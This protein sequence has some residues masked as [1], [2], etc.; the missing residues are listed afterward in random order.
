MR[1]ATL[2]A[3]RITVEMQ[4]DRVILRGTVQS[5]TERQEAERITWPLPGVTSVDNQ[6][7]ISA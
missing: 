6:I 2:D 1:N 5:W 7:T 3:Q 4:G